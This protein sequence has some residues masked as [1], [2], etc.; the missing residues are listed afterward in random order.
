M[1][2]WLS[3]SACVCRF[4]P[5]RGRRG[6][7]PEAHLAQSPA[8]TMSL[9]ATQAPGIS[10]HCIVCPLPPPHKEHITATAQRAMFAGNSARKASAKGCGG[11]RPLT[12]LG[13]HYVTVSAHRRLHV[14]LCLQS[15]AIGL[16]VPLCHL[17]L[18]CRHSHCD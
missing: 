9:E 15:F 3:T 5:P 7:A 10:S 17:L 14:N 16:A 2:Q 4:L 8:V 11:R 13:R 12:C 6:A 1:S 18:R